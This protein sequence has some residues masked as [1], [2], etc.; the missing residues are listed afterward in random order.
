VEV[1]HIVNE[2]LVTVEV[3]HLVTE[4]LATVEVYYLVTEYLATVKVYHLVTEYLATVEVHYLVTIEDYY[5]VEVTTNHSYVIV[6][7][8]ND[9]ID[10]NCSQVFGD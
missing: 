7:K 2:Y 6:F 9:G 3:Y 1:Y 10:V 8:Y 4:Y 5:L